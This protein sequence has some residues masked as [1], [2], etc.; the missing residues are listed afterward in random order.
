MKKWARAQIGAFD[1]SSFLLNIHAYTED[2]G[3][4]GAL[5][6]GSGSTIHVKLCIIDRKDGK[7]LAER[8]WNEPTFGDEANKWLKG[9]DFATLGL[10]EFLG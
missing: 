2:T 8:T 1:A 9:A 7:T 5:A 3:M 10:D 6:F 4:A